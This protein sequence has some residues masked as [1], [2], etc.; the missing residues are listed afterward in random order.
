VVLGRHFDRLE[1]LDVLLGDRP[2]LSPVESFYQRMLAGDADEVLDQA[3]TLLA[4]RSLSS[5]YDEIAVKG[6]RL[7]AIDAERGVLTTTR[8]ARVRAATA[9]LL[10]DLSVHA[11][12]KPA[13]HRRERNASLAEK[14]VPISQ[15][16]EF[17][18]TPLPEVWQR[19]GAVLCIAARGPLDDAAATMIAQ[20]LD[21]HGI[22]A[23]TI[24][25]EAASRERL[26]ALDAAGVLLICIC[27]LEFAS[28]PPHLRFL[29]RRVR[30]RFPGVPILVTLWTDPATDQASRDA[31]DADHYAPTVRATAIAVHDIAEKGD[32]D[33][34]TMLDAAFG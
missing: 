34:K 25:H 33:V 7:A 4:D 13:P 18:D 23:R 1:F 11:D 24:L 8:L 2:A 30:S 12:A 31:V 32:T 20:V 14:A 10:D 26:P 28:A 19:E 21:K 6:L 16:P 3:E 5:Y 17:S 22:G 9:V 29:L 27:G 15:P